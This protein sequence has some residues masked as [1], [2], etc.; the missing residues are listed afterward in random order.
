MSPLWHMMGLPLHEEQTAVWAL[1]SSVDLPCWWEVQT[2]LFSK[3]P[4]FPFGSSLQSGWSRAN[5]TLHYSHKPKQNSE[6]SKL[7]SLPLNHSIENRMNM[8]TVLGNLMVESDPKLRALSSGFLP[9]MSC[10]RKKDLTNIGA[11]FP[12][13]KLTNTQYLSERQ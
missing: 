12:G 2:D 7:L 3:G 10:P 1:V 8:W 9:N 4:L 6:L 11:S 13:V 5:S